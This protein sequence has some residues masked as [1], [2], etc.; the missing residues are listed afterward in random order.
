MSDWI[1]LSTIADGPLLTSRLQDWWQ[2]LDTLR[3]TQAVAQ[4]GPGP[5]NNIKTFANGGPVDIDATY[6]RLN[7]ESTGNPVLIWATFQTRLQDVV[8]GSITFLFEIDGGTAISLGIALDPLD[9]PVGWMVPYIAELA[10]GVHDVV[11]QVTTNTASL[12]E[13]WLD[14][15]LGIF[16]REF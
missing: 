13:V 7:F 12:G 10:A 2:N 3:N 6:Y 4:M 8:N 11:V 15:T 9:A 1:T 14:A 16:A 5:A